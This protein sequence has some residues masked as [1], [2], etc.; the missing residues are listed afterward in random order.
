[1]LVD[2]VWHQC[3]D[4]VLRPVILAEVLANDNSWRK[5]PFLLDTGADRTVLSADVTTALGL[6]SVETDRLVGGVGGV[7]PAVTI[8]TQIRLS[9]DQNGKVLLRGRYLGVANK[10]ALDISV[11]GRDV[12]NLF[13]VVV[14]WPQRTVCLL[15]Q[16]HRYTITQE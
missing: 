9:Y 8:E 2:G 16:R 1:M 15:A 11:L 4:G 6:P 7:V 12:T 5:A 3:D 13:A 14:D 10:E